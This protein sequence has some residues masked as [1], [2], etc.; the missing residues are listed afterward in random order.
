MLHLSN[1]KIIVNIIFML[2]CLQLSYIRTISISSRSSTDNK[3]RGLRSQN[4]VRCTTVAPYERPELN[5]VSP[6]NCRLACEIAAEAENF[7]P[8]MKCIAYEY[9]NQAESWCTMFTGFVG[10][11]RQNRRRRLSMPTKELCTAP[12]HKQLMCIQ[13]GKSLIFFFKKRG[14]IH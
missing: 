1:T 11:R 14:T 2:F 13:E 6:K 4:N 3:R 8:G 10:S 12:F 7:L 9:N 5:G